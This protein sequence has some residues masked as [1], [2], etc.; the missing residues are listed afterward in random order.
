MFLRLGLGDQDVFI[1]EAIARGWFAIQDV[2]RG[3]NY[4]QD[5]VLFLYLS[6]PLLSHVLPSPVNLSH[7]FRKDEKGCILYVGNA[8]I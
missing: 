6:Q 2:G 3:D 4:L 1:N 8:H 7:E 5:I